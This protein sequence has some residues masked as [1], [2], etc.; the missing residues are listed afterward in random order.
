M[1]SARKRIGFLPSTEVQEII[2]K[3]CIENKLS[4]SKV[5]G[6]L[7]EEAL[8]SRGVLNN[9]IDKISINNDV[10]QNNSLSSNNED[11][12]LRETSLKYEV[13]MINEFI[14]YKFF[15]KIMSESKTK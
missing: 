1:P 10:L 3:I 2:E 13:K 4:Q 12:I 6:L 15:K 9:F 14:E 5:T 8:Q 11:F 7:V